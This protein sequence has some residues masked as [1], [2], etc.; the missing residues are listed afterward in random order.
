M[1]QSFPLTYIVRHK[2][3][4]LKKCS[5][6]GLEKRVD[7]R[8]FSYPNAIWPDLSAYILLTMDAPPLHPSEA[9]QGLL[10]LDGTWRYADKMR[11]S[12]ELQT[13][14]KKRTIPGE[15]RTAYPRRQ[16]D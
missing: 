7:F 5:L 1:M 4:N 9:G 11:A 10:I 6:R 3:E 16:E 15:F 14:L 8:F 13:P 2:R 12:V